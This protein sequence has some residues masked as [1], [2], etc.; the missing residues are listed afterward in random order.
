MNNRQRENLAKYAYDM[1]KLMI[2]VPVLGNLLAPEFSDLAFWTG[3]AT[4][5]GSLVVAYLLDSQSEV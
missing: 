1:S 3:L 2:A 5:T 4:A